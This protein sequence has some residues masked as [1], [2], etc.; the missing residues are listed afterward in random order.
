[1]FFR[2]LQDVLLEIVSEVDD[3]VEKITPALITFPSGAMSQ[4]ACLTPSRGSL[5]EEWGMLVKHDM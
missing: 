2:P 4:T 5:D 3:S 1:M